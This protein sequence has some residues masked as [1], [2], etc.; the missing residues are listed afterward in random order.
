[1]ETATATTTTTTENYE[2]GP[3]VTQQPLNPPEN[4]DKTQQNSFV[5]LENTKSLE[6][7]D[8]SSVDTVDTVEYNE[9]LNKF[10]K[11]S[12]EI[13]RMVNEE[14]E[15]LKLRE[16][17]EDVKKFYSELKGIDQYDI[18]EK[19]FKYW[20]S[21]YVGHW[22]RLFIYNSSEIMVC[23]ALVN[24][25]IQIRNLD[26]VIKKRMD[27]KK[28]FKDGIFKYL[29]NEHLPIVIKENDEYC[30][31]SSDFIQWRFKCHLIRFGF[32]KSVLKEKFNL[33]YNDY[34][35]YK[36]VEIHFNL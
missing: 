30:N 10:V 5:V 12:E 32:I 36:D 35:T 29:K 25:R 24:E 34:K 31:C 15:I 21:D 7:K 11:E 19:D 20:N 4:E 27:R 8:V 2:N 22:F 26:I 16:E 18:T 28:K 13:N 3:F 14:G 9:E 17:Y 33:N 1:M 23:T 6:F